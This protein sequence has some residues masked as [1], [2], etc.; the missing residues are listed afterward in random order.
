L[1][2]Y[3]KEM[4]V[5][6]NLAEDRETARVP[7]LRGAAVGLLAGLV[8]GAL[9]RVWMHFLTDQP[10]FTWA[11]TIAILVL[12]SMTGAAVGAIRGARRAGRSR[13]WRMLAVPTVLL[14]ASPGAV[15]FPMYVV[16]GA[17]LSGRL[18]NWLSAVLGVA[19]VGFGV[20]GLGAFVLADAPGVVIPALGWLAASLTM[21]YAGRELFLRWP[22]RVARSTFRSR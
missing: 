22:N 3:I 20:F 15:L 6:A 7:V 5:D 19:V 18:P 4:S 16:G 9:A 8:W 14:F 21:A 2:E 10:E 11:G 13:W 17:S 12:T 1:K